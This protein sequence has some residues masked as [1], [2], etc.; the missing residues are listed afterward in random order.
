M[1]DSLHRAI[2][3]LRDTRTDAW[4]RLLEARGSLC[5]RTI[6]HPTQLGGARRDRTDDLLLA[7]QALSQ[8]SYGPVE[9]TLEKVVGLGRLELP[10][11]RLSSARSNQLSYKPPNPETKTRSHG[12]KTGRPLSRM[13]KERHG[14]VHERKRNEDGGVLP[15]DL[16]D[17]ET[18]W[19]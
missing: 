10:T 8:L 4:T 7:K 17:P 15:M 13:D 6:S 18:G 11:S 5:D 12:C 19:P 2:E 16:T 9:D 14:L 3:D 1:S